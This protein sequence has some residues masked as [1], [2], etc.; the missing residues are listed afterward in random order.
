[1]RQL[2]IFGSVA[3]L[4]LACLA[5][6]P[7]PAAKPPAPQP[8]ILARELDRSLA[9]LGHII[10]AARDVGED[11]H[12]YANF[13][14]WS[15]DENRMMYA[16]N[17]ARLCKLDLR[18]RQTTILLEDPKG[19]IRDP[20]VHYDGQKILFS[21]RKGDSRHFNLY[22]INIDGTGL[23][24]ITSGPFDDIEPTYLPNGDIV[25]CSSRCNRWVNCWF[26]KVAIMYRCDANGGNIRPISANTEHDN[27]PAVLPD[28]RLLYTRWEYVDRSQVEFHHLWTANPDGTNVQTYFGNLH[29]G[30]LFIDS[31]AIPG[32]PNILSIFSPGHG[33]KEHNGVLTIVRPDVGPDDKSAATPVKGVPGSVRDPWPLT[34]TL[35]LVARRNQILLVDAA[36]GEHEVIHTD[37]QELHEPAPVTPRP[38]ETIIPDRVR[39][40]EQTGRL[41][42]ADAHIGRNMAGVE[43][44]DI[45]R[46]LVLESLPKPINF[47]GG[48][49]PLTSLG[50]FTLERVVGTVPVE[51]DGSA[52]IELPANRQFFFVALDD[53][54]MSVKRMQSWVSVMPGETTGCVGCHEQRTQ[55]APASLNLQALRRAPSKIEPFADVPDVIDFPR[56]IQP[57][58]DR[59]CTGC[60]DYAGPRDAAARRVV[61]AARAAGQGSRPLPS[62]SPHY[63]AGGVVLTGDHLSTYSTSYWMLIYSGQVSDG[64]NAYGN[65]PP[66]SIG[67]SASPLMQKIDGSHHGV[68]VSER[69][70][71]LIWMW[72]ESGATYSGT[73]ASLGS[74]M[75]GVNLF[76]DLSKADAKRPPAHEIIEQRC[77]S[78]HAQPINGKLAEGRIELPAGRPPRRPGEAA[79]ERVVRPNEPML[80]RS[81][82]AL[83]NLTR[84]EMS[85]LLLAPLSR[86]AGG[87]ESCGQ[88][89]FADTTDPDYQKLLGIIRRPAE[90]LARIKRFDMPGFRPNNHYV[91]EM[92]RYGILPAS[93]DNTRDPID[94]YEVDRAYW[95]SMWWT[96]Q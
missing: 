3:L 66:R 48:P 79:H 56:D 70:R 96:G 38:R 15:E 45:R 13:G 34:S 76:G 63:P 91:R 53:K 58:L 4:M 46:L 47:S 67:S 41:V 24:Q 86:Q 7:A 94:V 12:W 49:E 72:I 40:Q 77:N 65:R 9:H 28:G 11:S 52:Y 1:M 60:H 25:F 14:Y 78:C 69:E 62:S 82:Q 80:R 2:P 84:P 27:T 90:H 18:T 95:E 83:S 89:V 23:R 75:T 85:I 68:T 21:Y 50:T 57:I 51:P 59:S 92:K 39:L 36:A 73:Y 88:P 30:G 19:S 43:R 32:T 20:Q 5:A 81:T 61:D 26:T 35:F 71:R 55:V 33:Q 64:A 74:G 17:G 10:F 31:K 22:E 8:A 93:F 54:D 37:P 6:A 87:W 29:P 44:G 16:P 42:V